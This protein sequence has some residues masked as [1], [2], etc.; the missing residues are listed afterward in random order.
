M[1]P[2]LQALPIA[3]PVAGWAAHALFLARRLHTARTDP[4]TGLMGRAAFTRRSLRAIRHPHAVVLLLDLDEFKA[5]NDE[6]GHAAGD[7]VLAAVGQRL[8]V[9][10]AT[11]HGFATRLGGDEFA[12]VARLAPDVDLHVEMLH[13]LWAR[14]VEPVETGAAVLYPRVSIGVCAAHHRPGADLPELQ[15]GAD[16]AM[17]RAKRLGHRWQPAM[18]QDVYATVNGR[19][20][21]R[22]GT[23]RPAASAR[24]GDR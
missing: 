22:P 11:W 1:T 3:A 21:G 9:W 12:A 7:A 5:I 17:Y 6:Y 10:S 18:A 14:L 2:V 15:R 24:K 20:I 23:G 4:L 19:R 13:V 16:E 8:A